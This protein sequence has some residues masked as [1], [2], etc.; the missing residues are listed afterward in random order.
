MIKEFS[1]HIR[2]QPVRQEVTDA[3]D[4]MTLEP[5]TL[6]I[7]PES[8][9]DGTYWTV[10]KVFTVE[11]PSAVILRQFRTMTSCIV[12]VFDHT[13]SSYQIGSE[14]IPARA[15]VSVYLNNASLTIEAEM[16]AN[17]IG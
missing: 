13:G 9:D 7:Q 12:Y 16:I 10:S 2:L 5:F 1:N 14:D 4:L 8:D 17:P 15:I 6:D 3:A 11:T